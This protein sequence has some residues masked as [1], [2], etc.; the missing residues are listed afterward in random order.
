MNIIRDYFSEFQNAEVVHDFFGKWPTLH[1]AEILEVVLNRELGYDFAGPKLTMTVYGCS[2]CP[3][4]E[5]HTP[6]HCKLVLVF[7]GVEIAFI[8]DF[9]H[10]NAIADFQMER[11]YCERRR[12]DRYRI[13][14]GEFG[15][16]M[17][18]TF[19]TASVVS[20]EPFEPADY[21]TSVGR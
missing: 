5:P 16:T 19:K 11:C 14:I 2:D 17:D 9:N 20:I 10:Q 6:K 21:F 3:T 15:A 18:F 13:V 7:D 4:S 1:D 12:E 8:K